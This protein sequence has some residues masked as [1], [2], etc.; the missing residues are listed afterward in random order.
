MNVPSRCLAVESL[1][2]HHKITRRGHVYRGEL[3]ITGGNRVHQEL[4]TERC[5]IGAKPTS[6]DPATGSVHAVAGPRDDE[7]PRRVH[8]HGRIPLVARGGGVDLNLVP[9]SGSQG[10]VTLSE[11]AG[12][13][14]VLV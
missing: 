6:D 2:G 5:S 10:I 1:P 13:V 8:T 14:A 9:Q 3:L 11:N 7:I 12:P 4:V